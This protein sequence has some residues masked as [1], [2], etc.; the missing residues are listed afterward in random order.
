MNKA[1]LSIKLLQT[2]ADTMLNHQLVPQTTY[3]MQLTQCTEKQC[4]KFDII[5]LWML[6]ALLAINGSTLHAVVHRPLQYGGMDIT[7]HPAIQD[8]YGLHY[9]I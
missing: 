7:K 1:A 6:I 4:R 8:E 5:T 2:E 9:F 3:I